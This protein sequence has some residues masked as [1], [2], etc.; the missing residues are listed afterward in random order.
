M[1]RS[2]APPP[3]TNAQLPCGL[4]VAELHTGRCCTTL[5]KVV[6]R[7]NK[8]LQAL[9]SS[10]KLAADVQGEVFFYWPEFGTN[11]ALRSF[12]SCPGCHSASF[13][14]QTCPPELR[15]RV[16]HRRSLCM[17][18]SST[19]LTTS[20]TQCCF[21]RQCHLCLRRSSRAFF[22]HRHHHRLS[23]RLSHRHHHRLSQRLSHH[24]HHRSFEHRSANA[25]QDHRRRH[26]AFTRRLRMPPLQRTT[27]SSNKSEPTSS[28][29]STPRKKTEDAS[30]T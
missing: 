2:L 25:L 18:T 4:A 28:S 5:I 23:H 17:T 15:S 29:A 10:G 7:P 11:I 9:A 6:K 14:A 24:H 3:C 27:T 26:A 21:S 20:M 16:S 13:R 8:L 1:H 19:S 22:S 12:P 30:R